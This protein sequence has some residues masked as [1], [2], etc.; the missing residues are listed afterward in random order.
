MLESDDRKE[1]PLIWNKNT[2]CH[3]KSTYN[4]VNNTM[5]TENNAVAKQIVINPT[6][7]LN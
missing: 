3:C 2:K 5:R 4:N 6:G 1:N 7:L